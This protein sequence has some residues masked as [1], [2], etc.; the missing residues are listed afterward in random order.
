M[1]VVL[2]HHDLV[3][4]I[5]PDVLIRRSVVLPSMGLGFMAWLMGVGVMQL[6]SERALLPSCGRSVQIPDCLD[7]EFGSRY[8][9]FLPVTSMNWFVHSSCSTG[10]A[11]TA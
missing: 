4:V 11:P 2:V 5:D 7:L 9:S 6:G 10:G 8:A 1:T 3:V